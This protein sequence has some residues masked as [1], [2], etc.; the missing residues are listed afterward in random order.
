MGNEF[1]VVA[2]AILVTAFLSFLAATSF[3]KFE[4]ALLRWIERQFSAPLATTIW[5]FS[6][7]LAY[8]V[9]ILLSHSFNP[10]QLIMIAFFS[11]WVNGLA[12]AV[13]EGNRRAAEESTKLAQHLMRALNDQ[14]ERERVFAERDEMMRKVIESVLT[15]LEDFTK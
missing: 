7:P 3:K 5:L 14:K 13:R 6:L 10:D 11:W 15:L 9:H 1:Q 12:L 8:T 4:D 2:F